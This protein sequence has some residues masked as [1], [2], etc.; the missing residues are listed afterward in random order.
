[1]IW[2][3]ELM[4]FDFDTSKLKEPLVVNKPLPNV[5][6]L[7]AARAQ[8][9]WQERRLEMLG[10]LHGVCSACSVCPLGEKPCE[11]RNTIFDPHVFSNMKPSKWM[12]VGQNPGFNECLLH[13]P[14]VGDAGKNFDYQLKVNGMSRDTFYI[15]NLV[16]CHTIGNASPTYEHK[17]AC[18]PFLRMEIEILHPKL[19]IT[20]GAVA[21]SA[22]RPDV[23]IGDVVG[24]I[25]KSD[26]YDVKVFPIYHP[27]PRNLLSKDRLDSFKK[28]IRLL[29]KLIKQT[30]L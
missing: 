27:S 16:R 10:K 9:T 13:K 30:K 23:D 4:D 24:K 8:Q 19:V 3:I 18:S 26:I 20:L 2:R 11:E 21:L 22:F 29:C 15:C 17:K 7:Y 1:M 6:D 5:T 28:C 14:F 25:I 12:V